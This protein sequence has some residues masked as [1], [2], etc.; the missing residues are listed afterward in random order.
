MVKFFAVLS[1]NNLC[2]FLFLSLNEMPIDNWHPA[3][4]W[5]AVLTNKSK[6]QLDSFLAI[7]CSNPV[8]QKQ[9][10]CQ[11]GFFRQNCVNNLSFIT[12]S[13]HVG[14]KAQV[15]V[16]DFW[17]TPVEYTSLSGSLVLYSQICVHCVASSTISNIITIIIFMLSIT[18]TVHPSIHSD[19][20]INNCHFNR[21]VSR[22]HNYSCQPWSWWWRN[23][24]KWQ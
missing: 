11:L 19:K 14:W 15:R 18:P 1:S 8:N 24:R 6:V 17:N 13:Y 2:P 3:K 4:V 20:N 10:S 22:F 5:K 16:F 9:K 23:I 12:V 7:I 21:A